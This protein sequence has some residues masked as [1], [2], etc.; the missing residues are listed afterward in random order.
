[1]GKRSK[2]KEKNIKIK[3]ITANSGRVTVE[4]RVT[5]VEVKQTKSGKGMI[6]YELYDGTG[7]IRSKIICKR[8]G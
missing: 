2:A 3:D 7:L 8:H 1:M 6:I 5:N 4:G